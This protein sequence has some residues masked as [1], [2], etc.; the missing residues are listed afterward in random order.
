V[1]QWKEKIPVTMLL[2]P[3]SSLRPTVNFKF[4]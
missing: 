1:R 3:F 4:E 2:P